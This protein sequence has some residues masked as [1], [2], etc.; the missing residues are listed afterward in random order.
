MKDIARGTAA[1]T[2]L[3]SKEDLNA[4]YFTLID[5]SSWVRGVLG[6]EPFAVARGIS[7]RP[8]WGLYHRPD[9]PAGWQDHHRSVGN[10]A[11]HA[12]LCPAD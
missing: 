5:P 2:V 11:L 12:V 3:P 7:A 9:R 10:R 6:V 1:V 8:A 4:A